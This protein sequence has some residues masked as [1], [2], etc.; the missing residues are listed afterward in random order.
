MLTMIRTYT[1][2]QKFDS[3][4]DRFEYCK[5]G[6][7]VGSVTFGLERY[8]NQVFYKSRE[9]QQIKRDVIVRDNGCDL[10]L[11][12]YP[13]SGKILVHHLNP[14]TPRDIEERTE[15]LLNPEYMISVSLLTHNAIHYGTKDLLPT[16]YIPRSKDDTCPWLKGDSNGEEKVQHH[17]VT[18]ARSGR[19]YTIRI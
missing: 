6:G 7:G 15:Y 9:W 18:D 17:M 12:D 11:K 13:I 19:K 8:M 10:G 16:D 2:L 1:E 5:L 14:I 4:D 3:L